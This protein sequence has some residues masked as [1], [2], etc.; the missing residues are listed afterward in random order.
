MNHQGHWHIQVLAIRLYVL[1]T[2][3]FK[4]DTCVLKQGYIE[5]FLIFNLFP[6][7]YPDYSQQDYSQYAGQVK[8]ES[9]DEQKYRPAEQGNGQNRNDYRQ[10][11]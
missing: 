1:Q 9:D 11:Y 4:I 10:E 2:F 3:Q 6:I 8:Y 5:L 7:D